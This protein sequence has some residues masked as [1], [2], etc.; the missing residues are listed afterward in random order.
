M[1]LISEFVEVNISAGNAR[2][3]ESLGYEVSK[4]WNE[5]EKKM[6]FSFHE[7]IIVKVKDL[8]RGSHVVVEC[9]CDG[10]NGSLRNY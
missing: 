8:K 5:H 9:F 3:F 4:K 10:W 1:G 7:K 2:Y 6:K